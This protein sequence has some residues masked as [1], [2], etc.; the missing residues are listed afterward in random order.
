MRVSSGPNAGRLT[1]MPAQRRRSVAE[2]HASSASWWASSV[3]GFVCSSCARTVG[4]GQ[5]NHNI[6]IPAQSLC[7][8]ASKVEMHV[9]HTAECFVLT[10]N[11]FAQRER[12]AHAAQSLHSTVR[13][14]GIQQIVQRIIAFVSTIRETISQRPAG[15]ELYA[16]QPRTNERDTKHTH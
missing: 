14:A 15:P 10:E 8:L 9:A 7:V 3:C 1:G 11:K 13:L 2:W 4:R 6:H 12:R 5:V 16:N